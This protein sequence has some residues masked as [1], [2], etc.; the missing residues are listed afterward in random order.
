MSILIKLALSLLRNSVRV[1]R[2]QAAGEHLRLSLARCLDE[3]LQIFVLL[4][5]EGGVVVA[6]LAEEHGAADLGLGRT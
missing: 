3:P 5:V 4:V 6:H 1:R 2:V